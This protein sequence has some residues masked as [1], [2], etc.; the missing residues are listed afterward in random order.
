MGMFNRTVLFKTS[1]IIVML[2]NSFNMTSKLINILKPELWMLYTTPILTAGVF[3]FYTKNPTITSVIP[4]KDVFII[5][6]PILFI[7]VLYFNLVKSDAPKIITLSDTTF[8]GVVHTVIGWLYFSGF[9]DLLNNVFFFVLIVNMM[10][11]YLSSKIRIALLRKSNCS[12]KDVSLCIIISIAMI[13]LYALQYINGLYHIDGMFWLIFMAIIQP[14][15]FYFIYK[16]QSRGVIALSAVFAGMNAVTIRHFSIYSF[17]LSRGVSGPENF[18]HRLEEHFFIYPEWHIMIGFSIAFFA[19]LV[20]SIV[21]NFIP[22]SK[23]PAGQN[24]GQR[25]I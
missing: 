22:S 16:S 24:E 14:L 9:K 6:L 23:T 7:C 13:L 5:L 10:L 15:P 17:L 25:T 1:A 2:C 8:F 21:F 12:L 3:S 11:A 18:I 4:L 19:L 20:L